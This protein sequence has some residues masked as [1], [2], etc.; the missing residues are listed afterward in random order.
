M[1]SNLDEGIWNSF[2]HVLE[3]KTQPPV[4]KFKV[5][6]SSKSILNSYVEEKCQIQNHHGEF[7]IHCEFWTHPLPVCF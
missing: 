7:K 2:W 1:H 4:A 5:G 3:L 6:V